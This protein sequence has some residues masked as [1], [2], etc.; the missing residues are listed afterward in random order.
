MSLRYSERKRK[1]KKD[2]ERNF[3]VILHSKADK[4]SRFLQINTI[5]TFDLHHKHRSFLTV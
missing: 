3:A 1:R 5:V 4:Q 2:K